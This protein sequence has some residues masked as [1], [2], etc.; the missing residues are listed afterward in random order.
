ME[1]L[2]KAIYASN[3][4]IIAVIVFV[5]IIQTVV[6][7][8][9]V[10]KY[11]KSLEEDFIKLKNKLSLQQKSREINHAKRLEFIE[12][13]SNIQAIVVE[14]RI[15]HQMQTEVKEK[16][17]DYD[18]SMKQ[19]TKY[20]QSNKAPFLRDYQVGWSNVENKFMDILRYLSSLQTSGQDRYNVEFASLIEACDSLKTQIYEDSLSI[21]KKL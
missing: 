10:E 11:K 15:A 7:I 12:I 13:I 8:F 3:W 16:W 1:Q 19:A 2:I 17:E 20:F 18:I 14:L 6:S 9:G 5:A 4:K 21:E